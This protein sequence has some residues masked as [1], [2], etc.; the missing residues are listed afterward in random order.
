MSPRSD[1]DPFARAFPK[2]SEPFGVTAN[3][4][5]YIPREATEHALAELLDRAR[6]PGC[7]AALTG[8][9]GLGKSLL[10]HLLAERLEG[11]CHPVF[12]PYGALTP[13]DLAA[14][15][16]DRLGSPRTDDSIGVL[17]AYARHLKTEDSTLLLLVDDAGAMPVSTLQWLSGLARES[18]GSLGC[19]LAVT[20]DVNS[21]A[22]ITA[23]GSEVAIV[24]LATP[25]APEETADYV[26]AHLAVGRVSGAVRD[27]FDEA[28]VMR[29]HEISGGVPRRLHTA[30][31]MLLRQ[32][33]EA[34]PA[35]GT[36]PGEPEGVA[37]ALP[38][39]ERESP[40]EDPPEK[41][42]SVPI[43]SVD[44]EIQAE[45]ER[46]RQAAASRGSAVG[47]SPFFR[48]SAT[49]VA[50]VAGAT[51]AGLLVTLVFHPFAPLVAPDPVRPAAPRGTAVEAETRDET[52]AVQR[53]PSP[54][55]PDL[56]EPTLARAAPDTPTGGIA[57]SATPDAPAGAAVIAT[58]DA[59]AA[60]AT[61]DAF[62]GAA[63]TATAD[64][65]AGAAATPMPER[66]PVNINATPWAAI[67]VDGEPLGETPL[68][69]VA[70]AAGPHT[71]RA[72]MPDGRVVERVVE[73]DAENRFVVF[74]EPP[75]AAPP[76]P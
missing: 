46:L 43:P 50:A 29:L 5:T 51:T 61:S 37:D 9:P 39:D 71:F 10:L 26:E 8:P 45:I 13:D 14:F 11:E 36:S 42:A 73:I 31:Q 59:P 68:A 70:L 17:K 52:A 54:P 23:L 12:L 33:P 65:P 21:L 60:T 24:R 28:A 44:S 25:M 47:R 40:L 32:E 53:T 55:E 7:V 74:D 64:T 57:A 22:V 34:P 15:A 62:T 35:D 3:P 48:R 27:S 18:D 41:A 30:A 67:E 6:A 63:V 72:R 4:A 19:V 1:R 2:T 66:V 20:D 58:S 76:R 56:S 69:G 75:A 16:L 49:L 38:L